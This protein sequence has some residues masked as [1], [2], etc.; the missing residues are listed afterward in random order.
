MLVFVILHYN[1]SIDTVEAVASICKNTKNRP[2]HIIIVDNCSSNG[3]GEALRR[4]YLSNKNITVIIN[5]CNLG[6][7]KGNNVG[8]YYAKYNLKA[9]YIVMMNNDTMLLDNRFC[10][11]IEDEY[12]RSTFAVLGPMIITPHPPFDSNPQ[13]ETV[14][15]KKECFVFILKMLAYCVLN[16]FSLD[17]IYQKYFA[18]SRNKKRK[19]INVRK[20]DIQLHGC[21][22]IFSR[23]YINRFDGINPKTFL[24]RE[25]ELLFLRLKRSGMK[26]VYQPSLRIFHKEDGATNTLFDKD[27]EKRFFGYWQR[28]KSTWIVL[29]ELCE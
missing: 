11:E 23:D 7:A 15:K 5:D 21:F 20:E 3:T 13:R 14:M 6:F 19:N 1:N 9:D 28:I 10:Q 29:Q 4:K 16:V 17:V 8:F 22:W 25:E 2:Y 26:S 27:K 24:Y 12:R 18:K